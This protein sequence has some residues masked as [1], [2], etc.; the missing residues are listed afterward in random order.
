MLKMKSLLLLIVIIFSTNVLANERK[1]VIQ[2]V[3]YF[4]KGDHEGSK[5]YRKLSMHP[6]GAYR[7]IDSTGK[8]VESKFEFYEGNADNSYQEEILS[9]DIYEKVALV[10]LRLAF[11]KNEEAEYKLMTLHKSPKGW[12]ITSLSWGMGV[13][14]L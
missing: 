4:Y 11:K 9:I 2:V 13:T 5:K 7:Y 8:Y 1:N 14:D 6:L 12:L 10:R 3:D